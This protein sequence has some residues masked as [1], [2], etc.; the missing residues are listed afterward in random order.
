MT[1]AKRSQGLS[2]HLSL[3]SGIQV[4]KSAFLPFYASAV[5][6]A[7][8]SMGHLPSDLSTKSLKSHLP[9]G[10]EAGGGSSL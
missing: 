6:S 7:G 1:K 5:S 10:L 3:G 8:S 4:W 2:A 9:R